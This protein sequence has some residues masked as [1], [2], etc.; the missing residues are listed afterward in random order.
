MNGWMGVILMLSIVAA[1]RAEAQDASPRP[2][3]FAATIIPGSWTHFS[4]ATTSQST[5]RSYD[6]GGALSYNLGRLIALEGEIGSSLAIRQSPGEAAVLSEEMTPGM[7][8][9]TGNV[10]INSSSHSIVP[11]VTAG[12]GGL[13]LSQRDV[14]IH[15]MD[16][17]LTGNVGGGVKW[18]A[19]NGRW[20]VRGDYR[21]QIVRSNGGA[22]AF[23]GQDT[24]YGQRV[25][26]GVIINAT[27]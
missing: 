16:T 14:D 23:F 20:G 5:F 24:R 13:T 7:F 9:Y 18:F 1:S 10:L 26:G 8:S 22:S 11:Y 15:K 3:R 19:P 4:T 6:L 12:I 17:L 27:R 21:V 2:G 25:Y